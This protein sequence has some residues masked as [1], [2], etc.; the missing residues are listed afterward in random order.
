MAPFLGCISVDLPRQDRGA[1]GGH[2]SWEGQDGSGAGARWNADEM[3]KTTPC[4]GMER[5]QAIREELQG[6]K[7][8]V[9]RWVTLWVDE[10]GGPRWCRRGAEDALSLGFFNFS[11]VRGSF[12]FD[13]FFF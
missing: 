6:S 2:P 7:G 5:S 11:I 8:G 4:Q 13:F 12:L 10:A 1:A 9:G 3:Q